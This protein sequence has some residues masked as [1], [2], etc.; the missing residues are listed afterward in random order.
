MDSGQCL[1]GLCCAPAVLEPVLMG[2]PS[3]S[4]P[5]GAAGRSQ[6]ELE[7]RWLFGGAEV[8]R[9]GGGTALSCGEV[10]LCSPIML[11]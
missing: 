8:Y 10:L 5:G 6:P 11:L 9:A 3:C 7:T 2:F 4:W 1:V